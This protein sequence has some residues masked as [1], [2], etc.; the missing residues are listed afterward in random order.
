LSPTSP[1]NAVKRHP[2]YYFKD[3]DLYFLVGTTNFCVHSYFFARDS[4][5]FR[6]ELSAC[7]SVGELPKGS[8]DSAIQLERATADEFASFLWTYYNRKFDDY[9]AADVATWTGII[10]VAFEYDFPAVKDFAIRGLESKF[11]IA[12]ADRISLYRKY[13]ADKKY[14]TPLFLKMIQREEWPSNDEIDILGHDATTLISRAR[15]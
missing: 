1:L 14:L 8:K 3:G 11:E 12:P 15:E 9:S 10:K 13:K 6:N 4:T 2:E 5:Q 7:P